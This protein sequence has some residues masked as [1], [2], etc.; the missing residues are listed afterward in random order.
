MIKIERS[1]GIEYMEIEEFS[2][3]MCL[4]EALFFIKEKAKDIGVDYTNLIKPLALEEYV[5]DRYPSMLHDVTIEHSLGN[6]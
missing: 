5:K 3:W 6:L 2:R 1:G 4:V